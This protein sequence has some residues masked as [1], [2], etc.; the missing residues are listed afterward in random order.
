MSRLIKITICLIFSFSGLL[1]Q[2]NILKE[3]ALE[4]FKLEHYDEAI[5]YLEKALKTTPNDAEIYYYLGFFNH[6]R[7]YDSRPLS[8]YNFS[9]S[10]K[11]F[12]YLDKAIELNPNYGNAKYFYGA[13]CSANAFVSMQNYNMD[14][15]I[16]FYKR[17][18]KKGAYPAWLLEF[19][20]NMLTSCDKNAILFTGGNADFDVCF[21]L[22]LHEKYRTDI[23][24]IPIG[25]IDRPWYVKFLKKGLENIVK[26]IEVNLT[27]NQIL[28]IHPFKWDSSNVLIPVS[29]KLKKKYSLDKNY[30]MRWLIK[31]DLFSDRNHS[32]INKEKVKKRTY[33]SPQRAIL[34]QIIEDNFSNRPIYFSNLANP[35]FFGGLDSFFQ[36]CGLVSELLPFQTKQTGFENNYQRIEQL[37]QK[38]KFENYS[39]IKMDDIPRISGIV[40]AYHTTLLKLSEYCKTNNENEKLKYLRIFYNDYLKIGFNPDTEKKY[41]E[42]LE[43]IKN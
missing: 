8:G 12:A 3:K 27:E 39:S 32:K 14:E 16:N 25:N 15:V 13:E 43:K 5:D 24:I 2:K 23:T 1:A 29:S 34:L 10:E 28:D 35:F 26:K 20:K 6:Y 7:A 11:I 9:Y 33:L 41:E 4:K 22:Q 36:N 31:P 38:E 18:Y 17:A 19:G 42:K 30:T 40:F 21:Y 37:L